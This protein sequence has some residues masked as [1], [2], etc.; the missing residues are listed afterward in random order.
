MKTVNVEILIS[1]NSKKTI[2]PINSC[3]IITQYNVRLDSN[4]W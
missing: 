1:I 2:I 3:P 4:F